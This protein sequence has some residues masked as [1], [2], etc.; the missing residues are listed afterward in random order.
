MSVNALSALDISRT[1]LHVQRVQM[2]IIANNI[3]NANTT[4]TAEGGA[5]RRQLVILSGHRYTGRAGEPM[6][7][8][9]EKIVSD[10]APFRTVYDPWHPD[11]SEQGYVEYPNVNI[12]VEMVNLMLAS[13]AYEANVSVVQSTKQIMRSALDLLRD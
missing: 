13:R 3:A 11:A 1:G 4:R 12:P 7:A 5:F 8:E 6:G 9:I 10:P 2:D